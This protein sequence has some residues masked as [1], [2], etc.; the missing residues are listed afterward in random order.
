MNQIL[1]LK[2]LSGKVHPIVYYQ[3]LTYFTQ[4][5]SIFSSIDCTVNS[6]SNIYKWIK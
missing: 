3:I 5:I 1:M 2:L 6:L 4:E